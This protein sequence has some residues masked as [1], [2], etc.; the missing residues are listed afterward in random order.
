MSDAER[1]DG[2][3][4][5]VLVPDDDEPLVTIVSNDKSSANAYHTHPKACD[6]I[7]RTSETREVKQSVAEW[8]GGTKCD[9]CAEI[10]AQPRAPPEITDPRDNPQTQISAA[11]CSA[12]RRAVRDG[13]TA[14]AVSDAADLSR[15]TTYPHIR[16]DCSHDVAIPPSK[17]TGT[18][19]VVDDA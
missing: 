8:Q 4:P 6:K 19:W 2:T 9:R 16:G 10:D 12:L 15:S 18:E 11:L 7:N 3:D 13:H 1:P 14:G 5:R 17:Y